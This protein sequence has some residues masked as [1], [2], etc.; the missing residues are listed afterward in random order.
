MWCETRTN[1]RECDQGP[2]R[3]PERVE[4]APGMKV[5][6][7]Q[8]LCTG[9]G[10][11]VDICPDVFFLHDDD[12]TYR[13]FVKEVGESGYSPDG[14]PKL[15]S[16]EGTADVPPALE[17]AVTEAADLCPGMCIMLERP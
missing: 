12:V 6:I 14:T 7:D 16:R 3:R 5:W 2:W 4:Q 11:C 9:D 10:Q 17:D 13:S 1:S 8:E 15:Q